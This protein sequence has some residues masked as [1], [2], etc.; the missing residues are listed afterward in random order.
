MNLTIISSYPDEITVSQLKKRAE[1]MGVTAQVKTISLESIATGAIHEVLTENVLWRQSAIGPSGLSIGRGL[2]NGRVAINSGLYIMPETANKFFQ[3]QFLRNSPLARYAIP[4][5]YANN[6]DHL[7]Q[8]VRKGYL[9]FPLVSKPVTGTSGIGVEYLESLEEAQ[10]KIKQWSGQVFQSYI[11]NDG[12]WRVFVVGGAAIG[13][14]RKVAAEGEM[15]N[16]VPSGAHISSE[17]D[18]E[19][20]SALY[21]IATEVT[22]L[23]HLELNG[24]DI[25]RDKHTGKFYIFEVNSSPGWQNGF[26]RVTGVDVPREI[27]QWFIDK[28]ALLSTTEPYKT[29]ESYLT[30][31]KPSLSPGENS[32][33]MSI[34][35]PYSSAVQRENPSYLSHFSPVEAIEMHRRSS[36]LS[37]SEGV[38]DKLI[39]SNN[40]PAL[41]E[42]VDNTLASHYFD[43]NI[44]EKLQAC[45]LMRLQNK[46]SRYEQLTIQEAE[47]N[48]SWAGNFIMG[49][50]DTSTTG[51]E[52]THSLNDCYFAT[53][54]YCALQYMR[55]Y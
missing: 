15:F 19:V 17:E 1:E 2:L 27:I 49:Y 24:V 18:W 36:P 13:A 47:K 44:N 37:Q 45:Y 22:S 30:S 9:T 51:M 20:K 28:N 52:Y 12:E 48:V 46:L 29:I 35:S 23:F 5:F 10:E 43:L 7:A 25:V 55:N 3:Q 41:Y 6:I 40:D 14:M 34:L 8:L 38:V 16:Y 33:L 26:D 54:L 21:K 39:K 42:Q 53:A 50:S 11:E 4:T 32:I 31:R